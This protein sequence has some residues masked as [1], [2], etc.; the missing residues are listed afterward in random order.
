MNTANQVCFFNNT[1]NQLVTIHNYGVKIWKADFENKK[2]S[3]TDVN[4]GQIKRIFTCCIVDA[5]DQYVYLGTKT[6]DI[7]E[8]A[9]DRALFKRIGPAKRLFS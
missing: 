8:V 7:V 2:V 9:L 1:N 3:Y 4:M 6:G 5:T